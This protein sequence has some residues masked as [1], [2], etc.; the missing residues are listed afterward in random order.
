MDV[1]VV[2]SGGGGGD[3]R[4]N[5]PPPFP[6]VVPE[7]SNGDDQNL[8]INGAFLLMSSSGGREWRTSETETESVDGG[9][10]VSSGEAGIEC[11]G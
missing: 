4:G 9:T 3:A 11:K 1:D 2:P 10:G 6:L 5:I 7:K 8:E